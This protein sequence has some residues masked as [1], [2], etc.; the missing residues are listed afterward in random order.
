MK[1]RKK[2]II[3]I[4][5][6]IL[7]LMLFVELFLKRIISASVHFQLLQHYENRTD[8]LSFINIIVT[9]LISLLV[10]NLSKKI[11]EQNKLDKER[12]RYESICVVYDY[13]N[14]IILYIKKK[15]FKDK[16]DYFQLDLNDDFMKNVY[17]LN[18]DVLTESDI[19]YI[20]KIDR[21]LNNYLKN[22]Q[23]S[24]NNSKLSIK[25]VYKNIFDL[26]IEIDKIEKMNNLVDTDIMIN[27]QL[28]NV[29]CKLRKEL[30]YN[31]CKNVKY[32]KYTLDITNFKNN[33]QIEKKYEKEYYMKNDSGYVQIY[34]PVFYTFGN[35]FINGGVIYKGSI[36]DYKLNGYGEY[37]YY[38]ENKNEKIY[39]NSDDLVE[40]NATKIKKI[41]EN[42][43]IN[44]NTNLKF[45]G[46]FENGIIN[47]GTI[48]FTDSE[49]KDLTI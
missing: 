35:P 6:I 31:Y 14:D 9:T 5:V 49:Q 34:E 15:V 8:I 28:L 46:Y 44:C 13:L 24:N 22:I 30:G 45:D 4:T 7:V 32:S 29:L 23:G 26:N 16:E 39:V 11:D 20:R 38:K 2:V 48:K 17:N 33:I 12:K 36:K 18:K 19:E 10:Y 47:N 40:V 3:V 37:F 41:L 21:S 25:W 1:K 42:E 43:N 27:I